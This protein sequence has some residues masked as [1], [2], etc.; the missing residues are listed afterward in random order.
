MGN[1]MTTQVSYSHQ[2]HQQPPSANYVLCRPWCIDKGENISFRNDFESF[3]L[4]YY[5]SLDTPGTEHIMVY[6]PI[7]LQIQDSKVVR[8]YSADEIDITI[9]GVISDYKPY[10]SVIVDNRK[11]TTNI[12]VVDELNTL[13]IRSNYLPTTPFKCILKDGYLLVKF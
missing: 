10:K 12:G 3:Q 4:R 11:V 9:D 2:V 7:I 1:Y 13:P 5:V 8:I 6:E